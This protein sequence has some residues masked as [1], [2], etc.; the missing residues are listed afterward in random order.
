MFARI[1]HAAALVLAFAALPAAG[2]DMSG[3]PE[4]GRALAEANCARCHAT[5]ADDEST[6][7]AAP[8]FRDVMQRYRAVMLEEALAEGIVTGHAE[9]PEFVFSADEVADL[10]AWLA[11]FED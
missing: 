11:Q 4:A 9:M 5:G 3:D 10:T 2:D 7:P 8:P 6:L 1:F